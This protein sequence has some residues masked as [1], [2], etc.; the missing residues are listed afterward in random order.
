MVSLQPGSESEPL[1]PWM[2]LHRL[3]QGA[4]LD[5]GPVTLATTG[6]N[7]GWGDESH[8]ELLVTAESG[9]GLWC[10]T[11]PYGALSD[12]KLWSAGG[13]RSRAATARG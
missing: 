2:C 6:T 9:K 1:Q 13:V 4:E 12:G 11:R 3:S 8:K 10:R 7:H 5:P